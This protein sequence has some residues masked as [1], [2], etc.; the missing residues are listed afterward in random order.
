MLE[1][2]YIYFIEESNSTDISN[3]LKY[4]GYPDLSG[5]TDDELWSHANEYG[6]KEQRQIFYDC[7]Y[8]TMFYDYYLADLRSIVLYYNPYFNWQSYICNIQIYSE[9]YTFTH[10][11]SKYDLSST[12]I[13]ADVSYTNPHYSIIAECANYDYKTFPFAYGAG[14]WSS[15][16]FGLIV[17]CKSI[18][19]RGYLMYLYDTNDNY[20]ISNNLD[21]YDFNNEK[22]KIKLDLYI[23]GSLSD[24]YIEETLE[25]SRNMLGVLFKSKTVSGKSISVN[26]SEI[27][28]EENTI[29][30]WYCSDL[31][32][33][34]INDEYTNYPYNPYR[35][36]L[37]MILEPYD[38]ITNAFIEQK[39]K[40]TILENEINVIKN[41]LK[42]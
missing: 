31:L 30:S 42:L 24:Y 39:N 1:E 2:L 5:L 27:I 33:K 20:N 13:F 29:L 23:N 36:R 3:E 34:N 32:S 37:I 41:Y 12:S 28:F 26:Y 22:T 40:I 8:N 9:Y 7:C 18:L 17:R 21:E 19:K 11:I 38:N 14:Q 25:P 6:Y 15:D 16:S 35:N 4:K 10:Y